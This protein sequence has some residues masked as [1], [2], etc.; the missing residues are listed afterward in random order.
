MSQIINFFGHWINKSAS[1]DAAGSVKSQYNDT[2]PL[3]ELNYLQ[4]VVFKI[5]STGHWLF[6]NKKWSEY[7]DYS[8]DECLGKSWLSH[9]HPQD[10]DTCR[11]Y[12]RRVTKGQPVSLSASIRIITK[13][14]AFRWVKIRASVLPCENPQTFNLT[15]TLT[16]ISA[17][18]SENERQTANYRALFSLIS[19][20]P[21]MVYRCRY[22]RDWSMEFVSAGC[23]DLTGYDTDHI[24]NSTNAWAE[25]IHPEAR[26][27][28]WMTIQSAIQN[29]QPFEL[30][31]RITTSEGLEKW[32]WERGAGNFSANGELLGLEGLIT[33]ITA[34]KRQSLRIERDTLFDPDTHLATQ[35]LFLNRIQ[36]AIE[37]A[38]ESPNI[39]HDFSVAVI[40]IR[41]YSNP[42]SET[43]SDQKDQIAKEIGSRL[44]SILKPST[45]L[46]RLNENE[47]GILLERCNS[48]GGNR[49]SRTIRSIQDCMKAPINLDQSS[50]YTKASIGVAQFN[51]HKSNSDI[52]SDANRASVQ[53][54]ELG[55]NKIEF[56]DNKQNIRMAAILGTESELTKALN[57][58]QLQLIC[59]P[60]I[61]PGKPKQRALEIKIAWQHPRRGLLTAE[62]FYPHIDNLELIRKLGKFIL[63]GISDVLATVP[64][65]LRSKQIYLHGLGES[66]LNG[67]L[68]RE[69]IDTLSL[70][71]DSNDPA[72]PM[73]FII[74]I[75]D[76]LL[77]NLSHQNL[78]TLQQLHKHNVGIAATGLKAVTPYMELLSLPGIQAIKLD[79]AASPLNENNINS[80]NAMIA[81]YH[82][83]NISVIAEGV[84]TPEISNAIKTSAFDYLQ[85]SQIAPDHDSNPK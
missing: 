16:D 23:A 74:D 7:T 43:S 24:T 77:A 63:H 71:K 20:M 13:E 61:A 47:F 66:V 8:I 21:G 60:L 42:V 72:Q 82:S 25:I 33:D 6:L 64:E 17:E 5:N 32:V 18:K 9:V 36:H 26:E 31:Y 78:N 58:G 44:H 59:Q 80:Y 81:C 11:E 38:N 34:T 39:H 49:L 55:A 22:N 83:L 53:A 30:T 12:L 41:Q 68:V 15:G 85:G 19:N 52:M 84:N 2:D 73:S 57:T 62:H 46:C 79:M 27:Y 37:L 3:Q 40:N 76:R 54:K 28:V 10:H 69:C 4:E 70:L 67:E 56:S 29:Q 14:N 48:G 75:D 50:F 45:T 1:I 51:N 35:H 65:K